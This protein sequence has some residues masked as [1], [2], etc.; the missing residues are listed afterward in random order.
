[1]RSHPNKVDASTQQG[2]P[3]ANQYLQVL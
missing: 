1:L 2:A 3:N